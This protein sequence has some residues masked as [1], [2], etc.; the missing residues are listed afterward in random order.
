MTSTEQRWDGAPVQPRPHQDSELLDEALL[1][2]LR[3]WLR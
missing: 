2:R 1:L 3:V